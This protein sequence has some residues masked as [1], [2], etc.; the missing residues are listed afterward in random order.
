MDITDGTYKVTINGVVYA[1]DVVASHSN[2]LGTVTCYASDPWFNAAD[3]TISNFYVGAPVF[4]SPLI[5][6][7][8]FNPI[9]S[10]VIGTYEVGNA[11]HIEF[12]LTINSYGSGWQNIIHC[13]TYGAESDYPRLPGIW[14]HGS[15]GN[16][17]HSKFSNND[18]R[19]YGGDYGG[20]LVAGHQY[21]FEMDITDGTYKVTINGKVYADEVVA[22]HSNY[23]G[24]ATC[25]ASDPWF[26]AADVTI[27][28]F[29]VGAPVFA[30]PLIKTESF[31][32]TKGNVIGTYEVGKEDH[33]EFDLTINSYGSGW[34]NIIHCTTYGAE[35][36]YPRLPGIW[37]HGSGG[38]GFHSKFSNNDNKNYGGD[39][40]GAL[41]AGHKY[42]F[43][44][45]ITDGTYKVTINGVVHA[46]EVVASHS[47]YLGTV[48]CYASDPWFNAA[49]V[50]ISNLVIG[51][52][53]SISSAIAVPATV[54]DNAPNG[55]ENVHWKIPMEDID[56]VTNH[57]ANA[58]GVF[59][60]KLSME[61]MVIIALSF[62]NVIALIILCVVCCG[63]RTKGVRYQRVVVDSYLSDMEIVDGK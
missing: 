40:G 1:D 60:V 42:H 20:A 6:T 41:V 54:D 24:T 7:A 48:T 57:L 38:N 34:Q 19:N 16:G 61:D 35:S 33:I 22:S 11:V 59:S 14:Y 63:K 47:N 27:S 23:L 17:F 43:E 62:V 29:Y 32:P 26:N 18:N 13:T 10:N 37:Y 39:Y 52:P 4:A 8:P 45:D 9:K 12:D 15:G 5:K 21:H 58:S 25:Y 44:M 53:V 49:A 31:N 46:D 55:N 2:Y 30:S 3:V 36:D 56:R 28:N 51:D 50:P